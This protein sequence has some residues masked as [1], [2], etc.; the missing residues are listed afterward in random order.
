MGVTDTSTDVRTA[1][2]IGSP[3]PRVTADFDRAAKRYDLMVALN[4]GYHRH[5]RSAAAALLDQL[6]SGLRRTRS[7]RLLDLGCGSGASTD[8]LLVAAETDGALPALDIVALDASAGMLAEA[9][10]KE[11]PAGI[12]FVHGLAEEIWQRRTE[13]GLAG[14]LDGVFAAYLFRNVP[15]H[16]VNGGRDDVLRA[17]RDVLRPGGVLVTQE[18]SVAGSDAARVVWTVICRLVVMPLSRLTRTDVEL[19]DYLWHSVLRFDSVERFSDRLWRAGF[20]DIEV[21]TVRGWQQG[22]L[23]TFRAK[24]P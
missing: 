22:I 7:R 8:A 20:V 13:W 5:L 18:Y 6:P 19:Y 2:G 4:P 12:R 10:E 11:W 17:V 23:H 21:R 15:E 1:D 24:A 9:A 14:G 3:A 16:Q